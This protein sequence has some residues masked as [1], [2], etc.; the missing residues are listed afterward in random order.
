MIG[1]Q[2]KVFIEGLTGSEKTILPV[3]QKGPDTRRP[4]PGTLP[5]GVGLSVA[6][7]AKKFRGMRH[8]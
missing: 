2:D 3:A 7:Y 1:L 8:R 5:E 4:K 6:L